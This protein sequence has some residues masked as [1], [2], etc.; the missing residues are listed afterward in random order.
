[1][2]LVTII[3][4]CYNA[5]SFVADAI[6]SAF[7]QTF[8]DIEIIVVD[9]GS[10]DGT[11]DVI[12]RYA[13][14]IR[15]LRQRNLG[16]PAARNNGMRAARGEFVQFLDADD[17]LLPSK[18][19]VCIQHFEPDIDVVFCDYIDEDA[20]ER[21]GGSLV[22]RAIYSLQR[23]PPHW[24]PNDVVTSTLK[25]PVTTLAPLFRLSTLQQLGGWDERLKNNQ[26]IELTFRLA[27]NGARFKK[28]DQ[29]LVQVRHHRS[30]TRIR[31]RPDSHRGVLHATRIMHEQA[32]K[33]NALTP[34]LRTALAARYARW[35]R[36]AYLRGD[37]DIARNAFELARSMDRDAKPSGC[38]LYNAAARLLGLER[39]VAITA[40]CA[41]VLK[42]GSR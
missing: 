37:R 3:I 9:D 25:S 38:P 39:M 7:A 14:R 33:L 41:R 29:A 12:N 32:L 6:E 10:T 22:K 36:I 19:E 4:P 24:D 23:P 35:G 18:V 42:F 34:S 27:L 13:N 17:I 30:A 28:I 26:D 11:I 15:I 8:K 40:V 31:M 5:E 2:S 16:A 20:L 1:M 21:R